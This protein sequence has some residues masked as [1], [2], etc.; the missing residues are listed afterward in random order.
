MSCWVCGAC[1]TDGFT[2]KLRIYRLA[3]VNLG[4]LDGDESYEPRPLLQVPL[5]ECQAPEDE[6][7][8]TYRPDRCHGG[9][10]NHVPDSSL[11]GSSSHRCNLLPLNRK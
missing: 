1:E 6:A 2:V 9:G 4:G 5:G 3:D 8:R 11:E 10:K 7:T